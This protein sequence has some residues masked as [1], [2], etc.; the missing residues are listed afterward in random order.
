MAANEF[1]G[2]KAGE[3]M[4]ER[5]YQDCKKG[6]KASCDESALYSA[7]FFVPDRATALLIGRP[8]LLASGH[9]E[10]WHETDKLLPQMTQVRKDYGGANYWAMQENIR[11]E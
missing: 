9:G 4:T 11:S 2:G 7:V 3:T 5:A 8:D 10:I 6:D 1:R